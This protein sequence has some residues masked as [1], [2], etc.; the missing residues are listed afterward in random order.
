MR[1]GD[2]THFWNCFT[3][4]PLFE[5]QQESFSAENYRSRFSNFKIAKA[6]IG[7]LKGVQLEN[8][9]SF[10]GNYGIKGNG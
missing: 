5:F 1:Q 2:V 3:S 9:I 8:I 4:F 6:E 7:G 10:T